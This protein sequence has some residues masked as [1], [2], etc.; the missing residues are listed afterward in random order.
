MLLL[1]ILPEYNVK[2]ISL[3]RW[4]PENWANSFSEFFIDVSLWG[5]WK[6]IN[7]KNFADSL[8]NAQNFCKITLHVLNLN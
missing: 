8:L 7:Y 6:L 4:M 2:D 5:I 3:A 1:H